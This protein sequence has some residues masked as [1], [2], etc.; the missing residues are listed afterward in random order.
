MRKRSRKG[1]TVPDTG[2]RMEPEYE[3]TDEQWNLIADLFPNPKPSPKG[4]RPRVTPRAC[5]E[6]IIWIL[7]TGARWRDLPKRFPSKATCWRRM[8]AWSKAGIWEKAWGRLARALDRQ[9]KVHRDEHF[10][11]GSFAPAKKGANALA[12]Q[13]EAKGPKYWSSLTAMDSL[14]L[15]TRPAP[16]HTK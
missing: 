4:G 8:D 16:V 12:R 7:R 5:V 15:Q 9:G 6:G 11:D 14:L 2:S 1:A 13:S 10:A 3:L